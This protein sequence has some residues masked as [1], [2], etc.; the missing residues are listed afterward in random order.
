MPAGVLACLYTTDAGAMT[1]A[2]L[3]V[4]L[5]VSA[6]SVST[7]V[8]YL[9][10]QQLVTCEKGPGRKERYRIDGDAWYRAM[11]ASANTN[12]LLADA[13]REAADLLGSGTPAAERLDGMARFL[14][15]VGDDL[16]RSAERWR[17]DPTGSGPR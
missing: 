10:E 6:A 13:S 14:R 1:A 11:V 16:I 7:A 12:N 15:Q 3:V 2:E 17:P 8:R 4:R 5:R 9:E